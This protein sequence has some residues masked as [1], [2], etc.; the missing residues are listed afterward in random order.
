MN[1]I[2][3]KNCEKQFPKSQPS[4][5]RK[6]CCH[7]CYTTYK[8]NNP[9][10][11]IIICKACGINFNILTN[12]KLYVFCSKICRKSFPITDKQRLL[13]SIGGRKSIQVQGDARRSKNEILFANLCFKY[14]ENVTTNDPIFEKWDADVCLHNH[15]IAVHWNGPWH[16]K[17]LRAKHSVA[18]VQSR[19]R[20]K[21]S[22]I[23]RCGWTSYIIEDK[24]GKHSE[25]FVDEQFHKFLQWLIIKM[26][27]EKYKLENSK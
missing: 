3:C 18:Q 16:Y 22:A 23:N 11:R 13:Q 8:K 20:L 19:D 1:L 17:K 27:I 9:K 21:Q 2:K 5:N 25:K 14:F 24:N 7:L 15:K 26:L 6:F 12:K 4:K 10:F